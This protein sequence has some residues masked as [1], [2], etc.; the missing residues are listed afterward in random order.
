MGNVANGKHMAVGLMLKGQFLVRYFNCVHFTFLFVFS[1]S[2]LKDRWFMIS[3]EF[4][5][6]I[7]E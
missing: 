5:Q 2:K 1:D 6:D 4:R 7:K 3:L